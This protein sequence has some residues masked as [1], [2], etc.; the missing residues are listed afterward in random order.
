MS[1]NMSNNISENIY[2]LNR[3]TKFTCAKRPNNTF[4]IKFL[5]ILKPLFI[6][7]GLSIIES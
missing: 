6:I 1:N 4:I 2:T 5:V 7:N 3:R